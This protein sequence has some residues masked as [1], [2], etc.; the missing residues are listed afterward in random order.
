M[1]EAHKIQRRFQSNVETTLAARAQLDTNSPLDILKVSKH[2]LNE[3]DK[4]KGQMGKR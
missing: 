3:I 1:A 4:Q 2:R